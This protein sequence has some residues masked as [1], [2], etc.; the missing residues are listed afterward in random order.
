MTTHLYLLIGIA[1]P[2]SITYIILDGG[3]L[4]GDHAVFA[5][6]GLLF[7]GIGDSVAALWGKHYGVTKWNGLIHKKTQEGSSKAAL[8]LIMGYYAF[9]VV[10]YPPMNSMFLII[11]L[12]SIIVCV[13]EGLTSTFDNLVCPLFYFVA[14]HQ[15]HDYFLHM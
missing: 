4:N 10:V 13:I 7:L 1:A 3:F 15:L 8:A 14:L 9:C 6:S 11:V 5:H 2:A 12:A